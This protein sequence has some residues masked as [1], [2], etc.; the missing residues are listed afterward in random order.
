MSM[1]FGLANGLRLS[2]KFLGRLPF[3]CTGFVQN[4][5]VKPVKVQFKI[6]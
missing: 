1:R 3:T 5:C 6:F 2:E 4:W